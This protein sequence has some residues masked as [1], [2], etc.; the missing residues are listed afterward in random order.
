MIT[1]ADFKRAMSVGSRW[2]RKHVNEEMSVEVEVIRAS[3]THAWVRYPDGK[4]ARLDFPKASEFEVSEDMEAL[5]YWPES[6]AYDMPRRLILT[7]KKV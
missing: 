1:L 5:L 3:S 7:Y 2:I 4:E 6:K